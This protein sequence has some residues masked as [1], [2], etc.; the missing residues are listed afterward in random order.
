MP[1]KFVNLREPSR[2]SR[3]IRLEHVDEETWKEGIRREK[4]R[5]DIQ[6][7]KERLAELEERLDKLESER[8]QEPDA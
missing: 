2:V 6:D 7:L 3:S 5:R 4:L 1:G 8:S